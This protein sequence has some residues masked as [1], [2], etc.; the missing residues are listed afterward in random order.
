LAGEKVVEIITPELA[1]RAALVGY[2]RTYCGLSYDEALS[3]AEK[4]I[5]LAAERSDAADLFEQFDLV[6]GA[7]MTAGILNPGDW[8]TPVHPWTTDQQ[9]VAS[10][11]GDAYSVWHSQDRVRPAEYDDPKFVAKKPRKKKRKL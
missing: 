3:I 2:G 10:N 11:L 6:W 9:I 5:G 7:S 1:V 4:A 8:N